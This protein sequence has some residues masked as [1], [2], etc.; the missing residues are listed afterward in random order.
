MV[1]LINSFSFSNTVGLSLLAETIMELSFYFFFGTTLK[2]ITVTHS[3][4]DSCV[5]TPSLCQLQISPN[6]QFKE[7]RTRNMEL[8][9]AKEKQRSIFI[10]RKYMNITHQHNSSTDIMK[11]FTE[12]IKLDFHRFVQDIIHIQM[13]VL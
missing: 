1:L 7:Y 3:Q 11:T 6:V 12:S 8:W 5:S 13:D 2:L 4:F 9:I 10:N